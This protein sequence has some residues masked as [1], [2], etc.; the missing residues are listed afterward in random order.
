MGR[1][2]EGG[3]NIDL[4]WEV[5]KFMKKGSDFNREVWKFTKKGSQKTRCFGDGRRKCSFYDVFLKVTVGA[6]WGHRRRENEYS[7]HIQIKTLDA[8]HIF[9]EKLNLHCWALLPRH[10]KYYQGLIN[11]FD[12]ETTLSN[13]TWR[14]Q[15]FTV[16]I[17][18]S[19]R[20]TNDCGTCPAWGN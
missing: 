12:R 10:T 19:I 18:F 13:F 16:G 14:T 11:I 6:S 5:M 15:Q 4:S 8:R 2:K 17:R 3:K 1:M 20:N 7:Y 9:S